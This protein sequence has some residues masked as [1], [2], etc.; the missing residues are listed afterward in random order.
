MRGSLCEPTHSHTH[1]R[2]CKCNLTTLLGS[3]PTL[4]AVKLSLWSWCSKSPNA[5]HF[6]WRLLFMFTP[7]ITLGFTNARTGPQ[8]NSGPLRGPK[9]TPN[10]LNTTEEQHTW[11]ASLVPWGYRR[12]VWCCWS[13]GWAPPGTGSTV[14]V[15]AAAACSATG[16]RRDPRCSS[17]CHSWSLEGQFGMKIKQRHGQSLRLQLHP[18]LTPAEQMNFMKAGFASENS[19]CLFLYSSGSKPVFSE[20]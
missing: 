1:T 10:Y 11:T 9:P 2:R 18:N 13:A 8:A 20:A 12:T 5:K 4:S 14:A 3:Q 15:A 16:W 6:S 7:S 19:A 17:G